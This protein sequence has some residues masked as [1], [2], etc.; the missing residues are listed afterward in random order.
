MDKQPQK[1]EEGEKAIPSKQPQ[2][3]DEQGRKAK[4]KQ[5]QKEV[6]ENN[7]PPSVHSSKNSTTTKVRTYPYG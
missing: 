4:D 5:P 3:K 6:E 7:S 1:D 2:Q